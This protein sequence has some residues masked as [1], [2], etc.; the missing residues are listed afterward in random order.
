MSNVPKT[1]PVKL[2][3]KANAS[4]SL[5][6]LRSSSALGIDFA[7]LSMTTP[8]LAEPSHDAPFPSDDSSLF[9]PQELSPQAQAVESV[10]STLAGMGL[11]HSENKAEWHPNTPTLPKHLE[12]SLDFDHRAYGDLVAS[13]WELL[14]ASKVLLQRRCRV[15]KTLLIDAIQ[16]CG[17]EAT[18]RAS[19]ESEVKLLRTTV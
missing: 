19:L 5:S 10:T 7:S 12:H 16:R 4:S 1:I 13:Q 17:E 14:L 11:L 2:K 15:N 8:P 9:P 3:P 18:A 6:S